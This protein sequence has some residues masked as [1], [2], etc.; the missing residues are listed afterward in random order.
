MLPHRNEQGGSSA[1]APRARQR[2]RPNRSTTRATRASSFIRRMRHRYRNAEPHANRARPPSSPIR[3]TTRTKTMKRPNWSYG[4]RQ[5]DQPRVAPL[6]ASSPNPP[7]AKKT[8]KRC[9]INRREI[10][11]GSK[12][13][14]TKCVQMTNADFLWNEQ[15]I[16]QPVSLRNRPISAR[17]PDRGVELWPISTDFERRSLRNTAISL[18]HGLGTIKILLMQIYLAESN[19]VS[20]S[21][22]IEPVII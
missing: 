11:V 6:A 7:T 20:T 8:K 17:G 1:S 3:P 22:F 13:Q 16:R 5:T 19:R 21:L 10:V 4:G 9:R 15:D 2:A 18:Y 12:R 14:H